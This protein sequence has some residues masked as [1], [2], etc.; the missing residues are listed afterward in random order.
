MCWFVSYFFKKN[1]E[2][3]DEM[4]EPIY[5]PLISANEFTFDTIYNKRKI[6]FPNYNSFFDVM[7]DRIDKGIDKTT[8][9]DEYEH[10]Y[11]RNKL[12]LEKIQNDRNKK[13]QRTI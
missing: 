1:K 5:E 10:Y 12:M 9:V 7:N 4:Y 6:D 11:N 13:L 2:N 3:I 8:T